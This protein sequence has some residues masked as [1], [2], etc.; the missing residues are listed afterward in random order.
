MTLLDLFSD[1]LESYLILS[2]LIGSL[3]NLEKSVKNI[4]SHLVNLDNCADG[5]NLN[6][7]KRTESL[8]Y[9][10]KCTDNCTEKKIS[11]SSSI[12]DGFDMPGQE[13]DP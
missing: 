1:T 2:A 13:K 8:C 4:F 7:K 11:F 9:L 3:V 12:F 10:D 5:K 6:L